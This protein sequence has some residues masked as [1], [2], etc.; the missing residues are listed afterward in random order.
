M[1]S[2]NTRPTSRS[3]I[4][5]NSKNTKTRQAKTKNTTLLPPK[6]DS[7]SFLKKP[8]LGSSQ[9]RKKIEERIIKKG[10]M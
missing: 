8:S 9:G 1:R 5:H 2:R 3:N 6:E 7:S 4:N 10:R